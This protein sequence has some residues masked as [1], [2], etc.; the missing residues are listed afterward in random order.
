[1]LRG[2]NFPKEAREYNAKG[3]LYIKFMVQIDGTLTDFAIVKDLKYGTG[4]EAI[5]LMKTSPKWV[6]ATVD[7]RK[8]A[9]WVTQ[10][11]NLMIN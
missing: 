1:F 3:P 6:P 4:E 8:V 5:R 2:Y 11:I 9:V 7:G 10:T